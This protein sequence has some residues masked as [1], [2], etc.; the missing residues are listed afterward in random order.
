MSTPTRLSITRLE[1]RTV[2]ALFGVTWPDPNNITASFAPDGT[3]GGGMKNTLD[4]DAERRRR[5]DA[6]RRRVPGPRHLRDDD[7]RLDDERTAAAAADRPSDLGYF[8]GLAVVDPL[9]IWW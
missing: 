5:P 4:G 6:R 2:P 7:R 8:W 1:D 9:K 3:D